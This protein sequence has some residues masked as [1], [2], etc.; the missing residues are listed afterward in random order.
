MTWTEILTTIVAPIIGSVLGWL[1]K[2]HSIKNQKTEIIKIFLDS[3][4]S[5]KITKEEA[6]KIIQA[7]EILINGDKSEKEESHV[8]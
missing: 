8:N 2:T 7:I 5:G 3:I 1:S 4:E 6:R